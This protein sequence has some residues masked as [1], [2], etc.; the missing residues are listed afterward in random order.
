MPFAQSIM[1]KLSMQHNMLFTHH[2]NSYSSFSNS[3]ELCNLFKLSS[4]LTKLLNFAG[5]CLK[6]SL[7]AITLP[8]AITMQILGVF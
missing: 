2:L 5:N 4:K 6:V 1:L 3:P 8:T 7:V